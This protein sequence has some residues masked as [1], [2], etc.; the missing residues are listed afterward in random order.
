LSPRSH[1][2]GPRRPLLGMSRPCTGRVLIRRRSPVEGSAGQDPPYG[3]CRHLERCRHAGGSWALS[4]MLLV[5]VAPLSAGERPALLDIPQPLDAPAGA[6]LAVEIPAGSFTKYEIDD[7]GRVH[8]DRFL[9]MPVVYPANYGSMPGT[10][11][12]DDDPLD[13][14]V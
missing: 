2:Q 10:R 4:L 3:C 6:L 12:G 1:P 8:V 9:S 14:L 5:L 7:D 13:A 11:A